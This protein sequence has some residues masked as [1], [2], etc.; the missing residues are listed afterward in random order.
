METK[1]PE[2]CPGYQ[3]EDYQAAYLEFN[4]EKLDFHEPVWQSFSN[5]LGTF[6]ICTVC[7][8]EEGPDE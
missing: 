4:D 3:S 1:E 7:G 8:W 5:E 6:N 2:G